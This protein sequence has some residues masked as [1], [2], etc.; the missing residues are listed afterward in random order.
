MQAGECNL[1][2]TH[3]PLNQLHQILLNP[4]PFL[5]QIQRLQPKTDAHQSRVSQLPHHPL[6]S[7]RTTKYPAATRMRV[8]SMITVER[9][10]DN[11]TTDKR[12]TEFDECTCQIP[13]NT[14]TPPIRYH[15][16]SITTIFTR[17][18]DVVNTISGCIVGNRTPVSSPAFTSEFHLNL[19]LGLILHCP[20][21][22][23]RNLVEIRN[24]QLEISLCSS[25]FLCNQSRNDSPT[26]SSES[27][28]IVGR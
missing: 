25:S 24:E 9:L 2:I 20:I 13:R 27:I 19:S 22:T 15:F 16:V 21:Q 17:I 12:G 4:L 7:A 23:D 1:P 8:A 5:H 6:S 14:L 18:S 28:G 10:P 11:R 26:S 3:H